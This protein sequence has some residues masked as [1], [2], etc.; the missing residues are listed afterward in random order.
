MF[1]QPM[2]PMQPIVKQLPKMS[3]QEL[4]NMQTASYAIMP[5]LVEKL[6]GK[7]AFGCLVSLGAAL[8]EYKTGEAGEL[9]TVFRI[10]ELWQEEQK[11]KELAGKKALLARLYKEREQKEVEAFWNWLRGIARE[12]EEEGFKAMIM[13][14][15]GKERL[16]QLALAWWNRHLEEKQEQ[17]E[18]K[19]K[20]KEDIKQQLKA[21]KEEN[22]RTKLALQTAKLEATQRKLIEQESN[23]VDRIK[24]KAKEGKLNET[25]MEW[26]LLNLDESEFEEIAALQMTG[27]KNRK[28]KEEIKR[29][30]AEGITAEDL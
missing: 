8:Q 1:I 29:K 26:A 12:Q 24:K 23:K 28:E 11:A 30:L 6:L 9:E 19:R 3:L 13:Q 5:A 4:I 21:L 17:E 2:Q 14:E 7:K 27:E 20:E 16:Q 18:Y 25:E 15:D 10:M 22:E